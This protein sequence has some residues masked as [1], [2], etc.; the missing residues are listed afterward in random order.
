MIP[1]LTV[2]VSSLVLKKG[3]TEIIIEAYASDPMGVGVVAV[4]AYVYDPYLDKQIIP[5]VELKLVRGDKLGGFYSGI[6][7]VPL[8]IKNGHYIIVV[9]AYNSMSRTYNST[10]YA[11]NN[12]N[13]LIVERE[14]TG[15][16]GTGGGIV[17]PISTDATDVEVGRTGGRPGGIVGTGNTD[18]IDGKTEGAGAST[19]TVSDGSITI[20]TEKCCCKVTITVSAGPVNIYVCGS[21]K[22]SNIP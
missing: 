1:A 14:E 19:S 20:E 2:K 8:G 18:F 22:K 9:T 10:T 17:A 15:V 16:G 11:V 21:E 12:E 6:V 7:V 3:E 13:E 4:G 5:G